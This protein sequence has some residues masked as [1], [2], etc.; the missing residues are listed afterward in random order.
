MDSK[1]WGF[2]ND[3]IKYYGIAVFLVVF[4][5]VE[6]Y[7]EQKNERKGWIRE[8]T[9]LRESLD[10]QNR[11]LTEEQTILMM[12]LVSNNYTQSLLSTFGDKIELVLDSDSL[13]DDEWKDYGDGK[14][15]VSFNIFQTYE[16]DFSDENKNDEME[17]LYDSFNREAK[18]FGAEKWEALHPLLSESRALSSHSSNALRSFNYRGV[19][20]YDIW[21]GAV[22]SCHTEYNDK[23]VDSI[24][25]ANIEESR[26]DL[27]SDIRR[28]KFQIPIEWHK[29]RGTN[30]F[31]GTYNNFRDD[32]R[33]T[34]R[35]VIEK[36]DS[37]NISVDTAITSQCSRRTTVRD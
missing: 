15:H 21:L 26:L 8:M 24:I 31:L 13:Y 2:I 14:K 16:F 29:D 34:W 10:P 36:I 32:L 7:P 9:L 1:I 33:N 18:F 27:F 17:R 12:D 25:V 28:S 37:D 30:G 35:V 6:I 22:S 19:P 20:L 4:Y 11:T 3:F 5:V 23:I